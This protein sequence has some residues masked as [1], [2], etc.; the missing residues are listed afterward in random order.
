LIN[1]LRVALAACDGFS[2]FW[3]IGVMAIC[4]GHQYR[5]TPPAA[6][7]ASAISLG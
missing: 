7:E 3:L 2:R 1:L 4:H 6:A 5:E